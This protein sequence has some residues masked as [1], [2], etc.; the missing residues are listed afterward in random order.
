MK[1]K[2][3]LLLILMLSPFIILPQQ[4]YFFFMLKIYKLFVMQI[5]SIFTILIF[6]TCIEYFYYKNSFIDSVVNAMTNSI[7]IISNI[8]YVGYN[9]IKVL[10]MIMYNLITKIIT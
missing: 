4:A 8:Y 3:T 7:R 6:Y 9:F 2:R 1:N 10:F 5:Y